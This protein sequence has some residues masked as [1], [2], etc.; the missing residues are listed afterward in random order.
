MTKNFCF[1][2]CLHICPI[3]ILGFNILIN[4]NYG[5][6]DA[7]LVQVYDILVMMFKWKSINTYIKKI[8]SNIVDFLQ[9]GH[10]RYKDYWSFKE[11]QNGCR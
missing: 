2:A 9:C 8:I 4:V 6:I 11:Y 10:A 7:V 5:K 3:Q 1:K